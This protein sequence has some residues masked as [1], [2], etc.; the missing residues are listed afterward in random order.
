M[1]GEGSRTGSPKPSSS[2]ALSTNLGGHVPPSHSPF[3]RS[4]LSG[5][6]PATPRCALPLPQLGPTPVHSQPWL[7][8]APSPATLPFSLCG[9]QFAAPPPPHR[10]VG[11]SGS[12]YVLPGPHAFAHV[13]GAPCLIARDWNSVSLPGGTHGFL[14]FFFILRLQILFLKEKI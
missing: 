4:A 9:P 12:S 11:N 14:L 1:W 6:G 3:L 10:L 8:N 2:L 5:R 13:R 7:G